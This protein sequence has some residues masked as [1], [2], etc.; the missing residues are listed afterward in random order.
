MHDRSVNDSKYTTSPNG[1]LLALRALDSLGS[2]SSDTVFSLVLDTI[3]IKS[4]LGPTKLITLTPGTW[5][6]PTKETV[7]VLRDAFSI[8]IGSLLR[9]GDLE[10]AVSYLDCGVLHNISLQSE[11]YRVC[12]EVFV[13]LDYKHRT[14][15]DY[16]K[17]SHLHIPY[18][19]LIDPLMRYLCRSRI[20][21]P[22]LLTKGLVILLQYSYFDVAIR[23]FK[24]HFL[25]VSNVFMYVR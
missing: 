7:S 8:Q 20:Y 3:G 24:D 6:A 11:A 25:H 9:R 19:V 16:T 13:Q 2:K 17:S 18:V 1:L 4:T 15:P 5:V 12:R 10:S 14:S 22:A 23:F 21:R